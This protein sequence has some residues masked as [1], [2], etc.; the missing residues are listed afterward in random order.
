MVCV[1]PIFTTVITFVSLVGFFDVF[2][3]K[4]Y[5]SIGGTI[6]KPYMKLYELMEED[7]SFQQKNQEFSMDFLF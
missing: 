7:S 4:V 3:M 1:F 2:R 6:M 5:E